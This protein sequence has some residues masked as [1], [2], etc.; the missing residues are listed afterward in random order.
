MDYI[1]KKANF[2]NLI[3]SFVL[4]LIMIVG[5]LI[6]YVKGNRG[7]GVILFLVIILISTYGAGI[8]IY[9]KSRTSIIIRYLTTL[10]FLV[11]YGFTVLTSTSIISFTIIIPIFVMGFMFFDRKLIMLLSIFT[12][13][14]NVLFVVRGIRL[15]LY[16]GN[17]TGIVVTV[18]VMLGF[19]IAGFMVG[20]VNA[21]IIKEMNLFL[22]N[23]HQNVLNKERIAENLNIIMETLSKTSNELAADIQKSTT[24][25]DEIAITIGEIATGA[26]DQAKDTT[27]GAVHIEELG[28]HIE[29][30]QNNIQ[31]I[32][33]ST[34]EVN[35]LK[36]EG[37]K[38][39][40]DL[41]IKTADTSNASK[42]I[43]EIITETNNHA[44][45]IANASQMI[46]SISNQTNLLA[47]NAA[48]EAARA[49]EAGKG[50]AVVADEIRKLAEQSN[51]FTEEIEKIIDA[52][53]EQTRFAV[54]NIDEV[55]NI[56]SQQSTSVDNTNAIF[57]GITQAIDKMER[58]IDELN[59]SGKEMVVKKDEIIGIIES[60]SAISEENA[61]GTE[62][63]SASI[64]EQTASMTEI[65]SISETL[66]SITDEMKS[67]ISQFKTN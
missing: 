16:E 15:A 30:E 37:F 41:M 7:I 8:Y 12:A 66:V 10:S 67:L 26:S 33:A 62:E 65:S 57:E 61:A 64:Q 49:G 32:I 25:A 31:Q 6:E 51:G 18:C 39:L 58:I 13:S 63:V 2:Y 24:S 21:R 20:S 22:N 38:I 4:Y 56:I 19:I 45:Q 11:P 23:E 1:L 5:F 50:F 52:L 17:T 47:L 44:S 59:L 36:D 60:L 43:S 40:K 9:F 27:A 34:D 48:I 46:K 55:Q 54:T 3:F 35:N 53:I 29:V 14:L 28:K 42:K